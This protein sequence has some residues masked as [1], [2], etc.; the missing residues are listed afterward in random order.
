M[1]SKFDDTWYRKIR[2]AG[3]AGPGGIYG[4]SQISKDPIYTVYHIIPFNFII[5]WFRSIKVYLQLGGT[6]S[7]IEREYQ[8]Y[9]EA[10]KD[11]EEKLGHTIEDAKEIINDWRKHQKEILADMILN[12]ANE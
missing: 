2:S 9:W 8:I 3:W 12:G 11:I 1:K 4:I 10:R 7:A 5:K 6:P